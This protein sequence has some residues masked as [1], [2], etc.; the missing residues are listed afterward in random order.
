M[1][2]KTL[3]QQYRSLP[4]EVQQQVAD[5]LA[6]LHQKYGSRSMKD[7]IIPDL[8]EDAFVGI[9]RERSD[10][11]DSREWVRR[12]RKDEWRDHKA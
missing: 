6:F 8:A 7:M 9:W 5:F 2:Q 4:D 1:D 3:W 12:T 11:Q 10:M